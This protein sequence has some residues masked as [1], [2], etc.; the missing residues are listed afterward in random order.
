MEVRHFRDRQDSSAMWKDHV[1]YFSEAGNQLFH[2]LSGL[3][4]IIL[5]PHVFYVI[6]PLCV[7]IARP[8]DHS[9]S[10]FV[11]RKKRTSTF[12]LYLRVGQCKY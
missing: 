3:I 1:S 5:F 10:C 4:Q 6:F 7:W 11:W 9:I 2:P 12:L 8:R